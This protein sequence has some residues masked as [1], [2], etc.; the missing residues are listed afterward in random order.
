M[1]LKYWDSA[2]WPERD[3]EFYINLSV[4]IFS[5]CPHHPSLHRLSCRKLCGKLNVIQL[6][7]WALYHIYFR[8][9]LKKLHSLHPKISVHSCSFLWMWQTELLM[10]RGTAGRK[11]EDASTAKGPAVA[12][13]IPFAL[14]WLQSLT[15]DSWPRKLALDTFLHLLGQKREDTP[16]KVKTSSGNKWNLFWH[17]ATC[18]LKG[19]NN[20]SFWHIWGWMGVQYQR[21]SLQP[22]SSSYV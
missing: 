5:L 17:R 2:Y 6:Q 13:W 8:Y 4:R 11:V 21:H 12:S 7:I 10:C 16:C 3:R 18:T 9:C 15:A 14:Q 19:C 1:L 22:F 20:I